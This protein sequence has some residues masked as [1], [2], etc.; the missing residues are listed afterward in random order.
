MAEFRTADLGQIMRTAEMIKGMRRESENDRVRNLY[1][2]EQVQSMQSNRELAQ[3]KQA[4]EFS[5]DQARQAYQVTDAIVNSQDPRAAIQQYAPQMIEQYEKRNGAGSFANATPE[6][7]KADL[8]QAR[9]FFGAKAGL[10]AR[11]TPEQQFAISEKA[12]AEALEFERQKQLA[13]TGQQYDLAKIDRQG[14]YTAERNAASNERRE[15]RDAQSLRKEFEG[16]EAVKN[17]RAVQPIINSAKNAPD[18]GY[19]DLDLIYATGKILDPNSVVREGELALTIAAGSPL[20]RII[21]SGRFSL[22]NGGRLTPESRKQLVQM[23]NGRV[24]A[25]EEQY[26]AERQRFSGYAQDNGWDTGSVVG[27]GQAAPP[28]PA[29]G[30]TATGPNGQ[31]ITLRNGQWVPL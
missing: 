6:S 28:Q 21:G 8:T 20:Q 26:N 11:G 22:E 23:L 31:K 10:F 13:A 16:M 15:F 2:G 27:G 30:P 5:A 4:A 7:L 24:G 29:T 14:Q 17:Y 12:K 3:Q 9:D 25:L 1:M 18:T 19:G